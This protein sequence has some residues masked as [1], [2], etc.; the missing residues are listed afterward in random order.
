MRRAKLSQW[1]VFHDG[2]V[3]IWRLEHFVL[4][5]DGYFKILF[6]QLAKYFCHKV[7]ICGILP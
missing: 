6:N 1:L 2:S 5:E 4:R 7:K 3:V